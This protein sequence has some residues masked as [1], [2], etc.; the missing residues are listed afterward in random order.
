[1][2]MIWSGKPYCTF[3]KSSGY[4][5]ICI[6]LGPPGSCA[7]VPQALSGLPSSHIRT[8]LIIKLAQDR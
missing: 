2:E 8:M 3:A 5:L 7:V 4:V 1:M 6:L